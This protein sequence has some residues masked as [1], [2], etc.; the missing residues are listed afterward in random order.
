[1][2]TRRTPAAIAALAGLCLVLVS[3]GGARSHGAPVA[4]ASRNPGNEGDRAKV[5][6]V[7]YVALVEPEFYTGYAR[8][9]PWMRAVSS[10]P[11]VLEPIP[12]CESGIYSLPVEIDAFRAL[13]PGSSTLRARLTPAWRS[14]RLPPHRELRE[15]VRTVTVTR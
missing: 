14:T 10:Q 9:F 11:A 4:C 6:T 5:G 3:C 13:R 2:S 15:Y 8:G 1:M 12:I 7:V